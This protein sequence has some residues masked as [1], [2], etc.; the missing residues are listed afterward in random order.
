M[1]YPRIVGERPYWLR[2]TSCKHKI[3]L[4]WADW[5]TKK[6]VIAADS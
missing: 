3:W 2:W 5:S 6:D 1:L 4:G